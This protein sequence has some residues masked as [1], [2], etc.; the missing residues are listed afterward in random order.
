VSIFDEIAKARDASL[1]KMRLPEKCELAPDVYDALLVSAQEMGFNY[2]VETPRPDSIFG[3]KI[4][5]DPKLKAGE[6][7]LVVPT[8]RE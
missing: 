1:R 3:L 7:K 4:V 2:S 6:W 8:Y 5:V